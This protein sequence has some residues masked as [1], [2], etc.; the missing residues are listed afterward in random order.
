MKHENFNQGLRYLLDIIKYNANAATH[1]SIQRLPSSVRDELNNADLQELMGS[2][3]LH[4]SYTSLNLSADDVLPLLREGPTVSELKLLADEV[5]E[6][7]LLLPKTLSSSEESPDLDDTTG[8]SSLAW[9][10]LPNRSKA[11]ATIYASSASFSLQQTKINYTHYSVD[12][13]L[14]HG[15]EPFSGEVVRVHHLFVIKE[16]AYVV[17]TWGIRGTVD[18]ITGCTEYTF[19]ERGSSHPPLPPVKPRKRGRPKKQQAEQ[20][21]PASLPLILKAERLI[22][23]VHFGIIPGSKLLLNRFY[24]PRGE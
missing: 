2:R 14:P 19:P 3:S 22:S 1:P 10:C 20:N 17:C 8:L 21:V 18:P 6:L 5:K 12:S 16:F 11:M 9:V 24:I 7:N 13:K 15:N 23:Y 4:S